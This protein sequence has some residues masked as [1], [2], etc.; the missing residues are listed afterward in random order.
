M[1]TFILLWGFKLLLILREVNEKK[2]ALKLLRK[3]ALNRNPDE[4]Y[5][6]MVRSRMEDGEHVEAPKEEECTPEQL[7][8]MQ[9]QDFKY[10]SHK[11][12][13]ESRKIA[14]LQASLHLVDADK[15][16]NHVF[17]VDTVEEGN[18]V[19]VYFLS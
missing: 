18:F 8:L 15:G 2:D 4:F 11:R 12:L 14:K 10:I 7:R 5:H 1:E 17:F 6:H 3:R 9:T 16:N 19:E 13:V